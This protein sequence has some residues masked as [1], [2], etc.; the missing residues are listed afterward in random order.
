MYVGK[1]GIHS[2]DCH[3]EAIQ[4]YKFYGMHD[5]MMDDMNMQ[6]HH[7]LCKFQ[8]IWCS[9]VFVVVVVVVGHHYCQLLEIVYCCIA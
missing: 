8:G 7:L 2:C 4:Q 9:I 3:F 1:L 5:D 6:F